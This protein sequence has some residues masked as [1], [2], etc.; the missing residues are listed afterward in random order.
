MSDAV[1]L[2]GPR[3]DT[4]EE[5][6]LQEIILTG[7]VPAEVAAELDE[8]VAGGTVRK[9]VDAAGRTVYQDM[10]KREQIDAALRELVAEGVL[11]VVREGERPEDTV[12]RRIA[13][14]ATVAR[15]PQGGGAA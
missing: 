11:E 13:D 12:Y 3:E 15:L 14:D 5:L 8:R 7:E 1:M 10:T 6:G 4:P 9:I 2:S